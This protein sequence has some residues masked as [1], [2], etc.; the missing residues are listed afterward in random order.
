ML[1]LKSRASCQCFI[2]NT[3]GCRKNVTIAQP[4]EAPPRPNRTKA[5]MAQ[6]ADDTQVV[7]TFVPN[8]NSVQNIYYEHNMA[9]RTLLNGFNIAKASGNV[10]IYTQYGAPFF[11]NVGKAQGTS[12]PPATS[13]DPNRWIFWG[14]WQAGNI[15]HLNNKKAPLVSNPTSNIKTF[16]YQEGASWHQ[17]FYIHFL[18]P[19][20]GGSINNL[21]SIA[22]YNSSGG[23]VREY[24][25]AGA[26]AIQFGDS[27][28]YYWWWPAS[29]NSDGVA[30]N[31]PYTAAQEN[32][33]WSSNAGEKLAISFN[34]VPS[35]TGFETK[36]NSA[37]F[38]RQGK[39]IT[40]GSSNN[41]TNNRLLRL[42]S[43]AMRRSIK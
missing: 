2:D 11:L 12:Y 29:D 22:L 31:S 13:G 33:F 18:P 32:A 27:T 42:K 19:A 24:T 3:A 21:S 15:G 5:H 23:K 8:A 25:T 30:T 1:R 28:G 35:Q 37:L 43:N 36:I 20:A 26:N 16:G 10:S 14:Y 7:G 34:G 39:P 9:N 40:I 6:G 17:A 41:N 4:R 38:S